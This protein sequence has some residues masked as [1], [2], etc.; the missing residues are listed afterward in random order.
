MSDKK[1]KNE[2]VLAMS[3]LAGKFYNATVKAV[4]CFVTAFTIAVA[5]VVVPIALAEDD[6]VGSSTPIVEVV[7][8]PGLVPEVTATEPVE[9]AVLGD[10]ETADPSVDP[11]EE[12]AGDQAVPES[13]EVSPVENPGGGGSSTESI[14]SCPPDPD[15]NPEVPCGENMI[16][17]GDFEIP[18]VASNWDIYDSY[19]DGLM[20][21][22]KWMPG[23]DEFGGQYRPKTAHLELQRNVNGWLPQSGEQYSELDTDWDGPAGSLN[24]EPGSVKI[25]QDL[26]TETGKEY[27]ATF[28]FSPRPGTPI[29]DN[30]LQFSWGGS[31]VD[32]ISEAG[33]ADV[34]WTI[35]TYTLTATGTTTR[36][37]FADLGTA[38]SLGV[39]LDNVFVAE[40]CQDIPEPCQVGP[41]WASH[42][43]DEDQG[44]RKDG[45]PVAPDR[46][47]SNALLGAPDGSFFSLGTEGTVTVSFDG[48]V[49]NTEGNDLSF[50]EITYGREGYPEETALVEVS[51]DGVQWF[52]IGSA[53]NHDVDGISYLDFDSTGLP[54][55]MYVRLTD[56]TNFALHSNDADGYDIDAID[57]TTII[58]NYVEIEKTGTYDSI[59]NQI[60]YQI[61]WN[62]VGT[63]IAYDVK[64]VD[65]IPGATEYVSADL[66]PTSIVGDVITW[67]LGDLTAP[68]S[69]TIH[70]IVALTSGTGVDPW[71]DSV[72]SFMQGFRWNGTPVL[73]ERS[74]PT[75]AL[76][77]AER[78]DTMNFVSLGFGD[79]DGR[80]ELVL[81]FDNY[82]INGAGADIEVVETSF[83]DPSEGSYPE[84]A[85]VYA[86]KDN[87]TWTFLKEIILD[88]DAI[89]LGSL[90]WAR[91]VKLVDVSD[92]SNFG[93][94]STTDGFDVDGVQALNSL[95]NICLVE[96][97]VEI[98]TFAL[99]QGDEGI[100]THDQA[101]AT[102]TINE[103]ACEPAEKEVTIVAHKIVCDIESE[104]PNWGNGGP[105]IGPTTAE[106]WVATHRSCRFVEGWEFQWGP[107]SAYDPGD[108]LVGPAN[109]P[110]QA[111]PPT[112]VNGMTTTQLSSEDING[113][114]YLWFR[115]VLEEGYIPFTF[116]QNGDTNVDPVSAEMYCHVD[117]LNFDNYDRID[118][119]ELGETYNCIAFNVPSELSAGSASGM[120]FSDSNRNHQKD[121]GEVGLEDWRIG[122]AK[123]VEVLWVDSHGDVT[124]TPIDSS[125]DSM[126]GREYFFRASGTFN[127]G[128]SI[129]A[130]AKY[131]VREPN[132]EWTDIVQNY[133]TYG[134][135]LLDLHLNGAAPD[136]G[137]YNSDSH[138]YW[139]SLIG[140]GHPFTFQIYDIFASNN[141]GSL[142]VQIYELLKDTY[143]DIDGNYYFDLTGID[144]DVI[145]AEARQLGW[146][147]TFPGDE[148]PLSFYVVPANADSTGLDFGNYD[149][150]GDDNGGGGFDLAG[151]IAD[152]ADP[153]INDDDDDDGGGGGGG[154]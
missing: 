13:A 137:P 149:T 102:T 115:E 29:E 138:G 37:E 64:I 152:P 71:A 66:T 28:Y 42:V 34:N 68:T 56:T 114:S 54:W 124:G 108:T 145:I 87:S 25:Y 47:D 27:Q 45:S 123:P 154:G 107:D 103:L 5:P 106:D 142:K 100:S 143:T 132:T 112:D 120:K 135:T 121:E 101:Q 11:A 75:E 109:A 146:I 70:L 62:I 24:G 61:D 32:T 1:G 78:N 125:F 93:D 74:D 148:G 9:E 140:D 130:D 116:D 19:I 69:G 46:S 151:D 6:G 33:G 31:V 2:R 48:Y 60:D 141:V 18:V 144:G 129:T 111:M 55:I 119:V 53:N 20:W 26:V 131:S 72:M 65:T 22:V 134:P 44:N 105:D 150:D 136:W 79:E 40:I 49:L 52:A 16:L 85:N 39:F 110:W 77:E 122:V 21:T 51:Q 7:A 50:H 89:D 81:G 97:N 104:L 83:G 4:F 153:V 36:V 90:D 98:I 82:I 133:E 139:T 80:G 91:Y 35:H 118:G 59:T 147:Q 128:D 14:V 63:G 94:G 15:P 113:G 12:V 8:D 117:V 95:P 67:E 10:Q 38:N 84:T 73:P 23:S 96:N 41:G 3:T 92:K 17:N 58:C 88:D 127:A 86:S 99:P 43:E 126:L 76:N 57:A 30:V